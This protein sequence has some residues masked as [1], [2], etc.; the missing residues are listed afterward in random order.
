MVHAFT[1]CIYGSMHRG[2]PQSREVTWNGWITFSKQV[3]TVFGDW[4]ERDMDECRNNV[5]NQCI[6]AHNIKLILCSVVGKL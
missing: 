6:V 4:S 2:Y 3:Q 5:V 1:Q